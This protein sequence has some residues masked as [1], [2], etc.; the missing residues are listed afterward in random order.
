MRA[1]L[2]PTRGTE[3]DELR[4]LCFT[5]DQPSVATSEMTNK[6]RAGFDKSIKAN[7]AN[8]T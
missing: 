3:N 4:L 7:I 8:L 6:I 5:C 1:L 2:P